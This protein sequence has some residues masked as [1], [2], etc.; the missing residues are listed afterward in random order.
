VQWPHGGHPRPLTCIHYFTNNPVIGSE[1]LA[2]ALSR[3]L[4]LATEQGFSDRIKATKRL[5]EELAPSIMHICYY[6]AT[7]F[8]ASIL[9]FLILVPVVA[10]A[11]PMLV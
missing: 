4:F 9:S 3:T 11:P 8:S 1:G 7:K 5:N 6:Q 2:T 10:K